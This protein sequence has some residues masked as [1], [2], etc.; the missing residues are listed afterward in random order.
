MTINF[1][2]HELINFFSNFGYPRLSRGE[3]SYNNCMED[4]HFCFH[5]TYLRVIS[6]EIQSKDAQKATLQQK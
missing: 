3:H 2:V 6:V 4:R 1:P 5:N